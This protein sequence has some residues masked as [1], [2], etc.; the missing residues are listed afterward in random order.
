MSKAISFE[1]TK[2]TGEISARR[3][4]PVGAVPAQNLRAIDLSAL[5][6]VDAERVV[7]AYAEWEKD[8]KKPFDK[9]I[10]EITKNELQPFEAYL[11]EKTGIEMESAVKSFKEAGL[12]R[13]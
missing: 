4:F 8:V 10:R 2:D 1:Y 3:L 11:K 5:S 7:D 6:D 9:K 12:K 13:L